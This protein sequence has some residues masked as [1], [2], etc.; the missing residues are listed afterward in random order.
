[1]RRLFPAALA[2]LLLTGCGNSSAADKDSLATSKGPKGASAANAKAD[3]EPTDP[4]EK[5]HEQIRSAAFQLNPAVDKIQEAYE[6]AREIEK[7][8]QITKELKQALEDAISSMTDAGSALADYTEAPPEI[9]VFKKDL[10][11]NQKLRE[12]IITSCNDAIHD[13]QDAE[14]TLDDISHNAPGKLQNP[15][16]G[17]TGALDEALGTVRDALSSA[18]GK[19]EKL[20]DVPDSPD[21]SVVPSRGK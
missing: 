1:M 19:E 20:D 9:E 21:A 15:I 10:P 16:E 2:V 17:V 18:G 6:A 8:P 4:T 5:L 14:E 11:K 3:A 12:G 7:S 13:L